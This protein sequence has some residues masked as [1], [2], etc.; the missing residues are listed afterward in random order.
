[1]INQLI[2]L[3]VYL[4]LFKKNPSLADFLD[5]EYSEIEKRKIKKAVFSLMAELFCYFFLIL[6]ILILIPSL[7]ADINEW[8][9]KKFWFQSA[10][11]LVTISGT[12][13]Q[14]FIKNE[15]LYFEFTDITNNTEQIKRLR[16]I[17]NWPSLWSI[18]F[19]TLI[20]GYGDIPF[21]NNA[22]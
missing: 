12:L 4:K 2:K 19:G 10:G 11:S 5:L 7:M 20:W 13:A 3:F 21:L 8:C 15:N 17:F 18:I 6:S 22:S 9:T 14:L 1:M 16:N